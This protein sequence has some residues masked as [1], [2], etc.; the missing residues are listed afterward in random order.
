MS[1]ALVC[2]GRDYHSP[3]FPQYMDE[4]HRRFGITLV[5]HGGATG[6]DS[7]AE[8][9]A[10]SREINQHIYPAKWK[11]HGRSAGPIRNT[12]MLGSEPTIDLVI[13]FPGG[14]GTDNMCQQAM[15]R[16]LPVYRVS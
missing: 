15:S 1:V 12:E 9:W 11:M 2:G 5:V 4:F 16:G 14:R 10:K 6:A 8:S 13:A 7:L 3:W